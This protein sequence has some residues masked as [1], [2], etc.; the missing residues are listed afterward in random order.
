MSDWDS[1]IDNLVEAPQDI[2]TKKVST[3][4]TYPCGQCAGTGQWSGG[5]NSYGNSKC[6]ACKGKGYFKTD[7]R[8]LAKQRQARAD[9]KARAIQQ[10]QA[11]NQA[12]GLLADFAELRM[13]EWNSFATSL[14]EQHNSGKEWSEKQVL[15]AKNMV[16]KTRISRQKKQEQAVSVDLSAISEL[17]DK[18]TQSGYK[19]P[20]YRAE[21]LIIS[22]APMTGVNAGALYVKDVDK[23]YLGKVINNKYIGNEV[24]QEG[25]AKIA[26]SPRDA[27][28]RYGQKTGTCACC[29]RALSNKQSVD[30]GIGPICATKW[31]LI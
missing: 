23:Q 22:K 24:A 1:F 5:V 11:A 16:E 26:E 14:L 2:E 28:I 10:A 25:L 21:G 3:E 13:A 12:T 9:K 18:A 30:L 7:P 15:S 4:K 8:K 31:G 29:G 20:I 19:R 27:A 17:F 6:R